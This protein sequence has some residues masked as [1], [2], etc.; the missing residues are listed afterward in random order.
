MEVKRQQRFTEV[1][2]EVA[3]HCAGDGLCVPLKLVREVNGVQL[4]PLD[5]VLDK[6]G[7]LGEDSRFPIQSFLV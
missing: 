4:A 7:G 3:L 6:L 5:A 2:V 1:F